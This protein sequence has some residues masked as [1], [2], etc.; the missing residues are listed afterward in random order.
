MWASRKWGE[1][2]RRSLTWGHL[3]RQAQPGAWEP[4]EVVGGEEAASAEPGQRPAW[5]WR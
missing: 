5:T 4:W 1:T 3:P 2:G